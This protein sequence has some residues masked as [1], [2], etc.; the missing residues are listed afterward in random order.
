MRGL[1]RFSMGIGDRFGREGSAQLAAAAAAKKAGV[2]VAVVWNKSNREHIICGTGPEDQRK[3][4]DAAVAATGWS[5]AYFVDADHIGLKTVDAFIPH[6]DFYTIDVA[7]S[8]GKKTDREAVDAFV[9]RRR[10]LVGTL[11]IPG[12]A[13]SLSISEDRLRRT[14]E[15]YLLAAQEAGRVYRKIEEARGKGTFLTEVSM[16]ETADPQT[17]AELAIILAALADEG[18][19]AD[20]IA[21]KFSG[22]FNKGVDYVGDPDAFEAEFAADVR[23]ASWASSS[24]GLPSALKLSV[25]SG[26]DKFSL[27]PRI[28]KILTETGAGVHLKTAGTTWLEELI[29][30]AE[31]GGEGLAVAAEIYRVAYGRFD[32]MVA[33]YAEVVD[34]RREAL[35]TPDQVDAWTGERFAAALRH[36]RTDS[37]FDP[38]FRQLLHVAYKVAAELGPR[39]LAALE[40]SRE[41]VS[42]NVTVNLLERHIRPLFLAR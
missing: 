15:R 1:G 9:A 22:R 40:L 28:A 19:P 8:I 24:F 23:V 30:I 3:A 39:F 26:S 4:A 27:Y 14:A 38:N 37:R 41:H 21:P 20:T 16:D 11:R 36:D 5:G 18:V 12:L 34:I 31:A 32:E 2:D 13:D 17:P 7:D 6:C 29:G 10:G 35:P 25:H 33:P 42:R